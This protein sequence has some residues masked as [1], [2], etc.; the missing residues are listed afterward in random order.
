[1]NRIA[2]SR[3]FDVAIALDADICSF[4]KGIDAKACDGADASLS[5]VFVSPYGAQL[6]KVVASIASVKVRRNVVALVRALA[7]EDKRG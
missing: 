1:M 3:L 2:A 5:A 6:A 4:F 7:D